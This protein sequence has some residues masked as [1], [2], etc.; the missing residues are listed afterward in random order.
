MARR[1]SA[2]VPRAT[3]RLTPVAANLPAVVQYAITLPLTP[4]TGDLCLGWLEQRAGPKR[5][6]ENVVAW[7]RRRLSDCRGMD[8]AG[9]R[10]AAAAAA[11]CER[12][13][14]TGQWPVVSRLRILAA[15]GDD[16]AAVEAAARVRVGAL[17]RDD[18]QA[19]LSVRAVGLLRLGR[20]REALSLLTTLQ[21]QKNLPPDGE[22]WLSVARAGLL[23]TD[24]GAKA[25]PDPEL[26]ARLLQDAE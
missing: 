13:F 19:V 23:S 16:A 5:L 20:Y 25:R 17:G 7:L 8:E 1:A 6:R 14:P 26:V 21:K 12:L 15:L 11:R 24:P 10:W 4:Q 18:R 2:P 9:L 3:P 22:R